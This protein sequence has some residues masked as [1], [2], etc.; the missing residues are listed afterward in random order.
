MEKI[1][2]SHST[3]PLKRLWHESQGLSSSDDPNHGHHLLGHSMTPISLEDVDI[4]DPE[5]TRREAVGLAMA[6]DKYER[7]I[8]KGRV[9]EAY[10]C[11]SAVKIMYQALLGIQDIDTGWGE[12]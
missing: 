1:N 2:D 4:H 9:Q 8:A 10:G 5:L 12:L 11:A 6:K 3:L 7:Y